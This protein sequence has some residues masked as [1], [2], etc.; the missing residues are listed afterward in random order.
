[1][2]A[3]ESFYS[4]EL[5]KMPVQNPILTDLI[6]KRYAKTGAE[7]YYAKEY[8]VAT[9]PEYLF[10]TDSEQKWTKP[11]TEQN[12]CVLSK[13]VK[14]P[15]C[16]AIELINNNYVYS[17]NDKETLYQNLIEW[18][19]KHFSNP[20]EKPEKYLKHAKERLRFFTMSYEPVEEEPDIVL[21]I[22][23]NMDLIAMSNANMYPIC[24]VSHM[25]EDYPHV[26]F[27]YMV[28]PH[29]TLKP[30]DIKNIPHIDAIL[31]VAYE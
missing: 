5:A 22:V 21:D 13:I 18:Q 1:M 20:L 23:K 9:Y 24:A 17:F 12:I 11:E 25:D 31:G 6:I 30:R 29:M 7:D 4:R 2:L 19:I 14:Q 26:H 15:D 16:E 28:D 27:L 8:S 10:R 3:L